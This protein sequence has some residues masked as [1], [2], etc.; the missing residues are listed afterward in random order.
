[1]DTAARQVR[2]AQNQSLYREVNERLEGIA[3][4][5]RYVAESTSFIC[6]CADTACAGRIELQLSEYEAVRAEA[7]RF[8]VLPNHVFPDVERVV[9]S[10]E[11]FDV[12]EKIEAGAKAAAA[13][14]PR[15]SA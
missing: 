9:A 4:T 2:A 8:V 15:S 11:R 6:E 12:V 10:N 1:M 13:V 7:N 14:D 3:S 5:F